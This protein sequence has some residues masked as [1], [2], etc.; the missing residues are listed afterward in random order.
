[1][2]TLH[3]SAIFHSHVQQ[4]RLHPLHGKRPF[5]WEQQPGSRHD[6]VLVLGGQSG[7]FGGNVSHTGGVVHVRPW[8]VV[9]LSFRGG[10]NQRPHHGKPLFLTDLDCLSP[11]N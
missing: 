8:I 10:I 6:R 3:S 4:E 9:E 2:S 5:E 1:M 7:A 11:M